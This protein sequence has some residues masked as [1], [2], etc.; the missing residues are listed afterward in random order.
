MKSSEIKI[1]FS[2]LGTQLGGSQWLDGGWM[3][4]LGLWVEH[5]HL[6]L[7]AVMA[8]DFAEADQT[9]LDAE[10]QVIEGLGAGNQVKWGR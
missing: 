6:H 10:H 2:K 7:V 8:V 4:D 3:T 5:A 1:S 9:G